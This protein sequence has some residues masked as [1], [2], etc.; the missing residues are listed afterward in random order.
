MGASIRR[1]CLTVL[2]AVTL[3]VLLLLYT[4]FGL[5]WLGQLAGPLSGGTARVD[6]LG[7]FFPNRL[8]AARVEISDSQGV[9]LRIEQP[10]LAWSALALVSNH[11]SAQDLKAERITVLRR[12]VPSRKASG[13]NPRIDIDHL[14]LARIELA[15]PVIGHAVTL[16]AAGALHYISLDQM[17]ADLLV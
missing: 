9:W 6:G 7:G 15:A 12:P 11:V 10:S 16:S 13:E 5:A 8:H 1:W 4:P 2:G 3:V 17:E 14:A